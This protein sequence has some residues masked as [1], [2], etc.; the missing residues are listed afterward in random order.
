MIFFYINII[1]FDFQIS[2]VTIIIF[3]L[4]LTTILLIILI[5]L[6]L[7]N[8]KN[9]RKKLELDLIDIKNNKNF[10]KLMN[11]VEIEINKII[12]LFKK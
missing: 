8:L 10:Y 11:S 12:K 5:M 3:F 1:I 4:L 2:I 9:R 6:F 7:I